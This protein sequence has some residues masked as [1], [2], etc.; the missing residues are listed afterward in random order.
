MHKHVLGLVPGRY[1][2]AA[3]KPCPVQGGLCVQKTK[4]L[5]DESKEINYVPLYP[6]ML[7]LTAT[8][9]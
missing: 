5:V 7:G 3:G 9:F 2:L 8:S 6:Q 4:V 1:Q